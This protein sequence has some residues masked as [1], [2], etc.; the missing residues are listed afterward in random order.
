MDR[1]VK[2]SKQN[3]KAIVDHTDT[4]KSKVSLNGT[5]PQLLNIFKVRDYMSKVTDI[6]I[7][8]TDDEHDR[9]FASGDNFVLFLH[10]LKK[11]TDKLELIEE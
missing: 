4:S 7:I 5:F 11:G 2:I 8:F 1:I 3:I 6:K 9:I 10:I